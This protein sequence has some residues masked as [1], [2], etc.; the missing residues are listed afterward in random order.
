MGNVSTFGTYTMAKLGI[1]AAQKALD[2]VGNN[3]S[4][5]NT[6]GY[7]RQYVDQISL[8]MGASDRMLSK[9]DTRIGS[10]ALVES[11]SQRR[12]EYLDLR[13]RASQSSVGAT[14]T[15]VDGLNQIADILDEV[16]KGDDGA[17]V[18]EARFNEMIQMMERLNTEGA[19]KD[20]FDTLFRSSAAS[21]V[22]TIRSYAGQLDTIME[23]QTD[24]LR[25]QV[26]EVNKIIDQIQDLNV[27]IRRTD[28]Y[29]GNC[30]ELKDERNLLL[31][32]LST[33]IKINASYEKEYVGENR[34]VDKLVIKTGNDPQRTFVD[35]IFASHFSIR[36]IT[37]TE[38]R[39]VRDADTGELRTITLKGEPY[40]DPLFNINISEMRDPDGRVKIVK[41]YDQGPVQVTQEENPPEGKEPE[42]IA[43]YGPTV[44]PTIYTTAE[45]AANA[46][47]KLNAQLTGDQRFFVDEESGESRELKY[48]IMHD[49]NTNGY[50]VIRTE[51]FRGEVQ[52]SD[53]E[54]YGAIQSQRELV[55]K[56]SVFSTAE[57]LE[58]DPNAATKRGIP[59]YQKALDVLANRMATLLN[60]AN[61]STNDGGV[62]FSNTGDA[63]TWGQSGEEGDELINAHNIS[64]SKSW[65]N[66]SFRV[67]TSQY[68]DDRSTA[69]ENLNRIL[70]ILINDQVYVPQAG[71]LYDDAVSTEVF[72]TGT[73]Q[74]LLTNHMSGTLAE[75]IMISQSMLENHEL[76][77]NDL[78]VNREGVS[79]VDLNDEAMDMM[80]YQKSFAAACRLMTVYDEMLDKLIN[81]TAV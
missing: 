10:G 59:Y 40:E 28:I 53:T 16:N 5:V 69:K 3:I 33:Y 67:E 26:E 47:V 6:E 22:D 36:T 52:C 77:S 2:V 78:Y 75:D 74:E 63:D 48:E 43:E 13:Y 23:T 37:P 45:Q 50:L 61:V 68:K 12:D 71:G 54:L 41:T 15:M 20:E 11:I 55:T 7:T 57:D 79:G 72:F 80:V 49:E 19:G 17:G 32:Q 29:G 4:N 34:Y 60:G 24:R 62:L 70:N 31:D 44:Y 30:L 8:N 21:L 1:Y 9:L 73:F 56:S 76:V 65:A 27:S 64:I 18:L 81:G 42:L 51:I 35:G 38:D 46:Q 14:E 58:A 25:N 39:E 66:G